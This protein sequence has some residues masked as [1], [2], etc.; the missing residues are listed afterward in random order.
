MIIP[1][2]YKLGDL[3]LGELTDGMFI[4]QGKMPMYKNTLLNASE[5]DLEPYNGDEKIELT[6]EQF[7]EMT[8]NYFRTLKKVEGF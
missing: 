4:S 5:Y 8:R 2:Q 1:M 6:D 7:N 3:L